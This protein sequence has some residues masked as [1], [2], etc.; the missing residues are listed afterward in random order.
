MEALIADIESDM[1]LLKKVTESIERK[2]ARLKTEKDRENIDSHNK[3]IAASLH[4]IYSGYE[5]VIERIV[6]AIDGEAPLGTQYHMRF[7]SG[8]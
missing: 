4:S 6:R 1:K 5:T 7:S 2:L 8:Q 3:A